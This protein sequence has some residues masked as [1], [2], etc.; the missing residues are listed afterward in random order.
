MMCR[1]KQNDTCHKNKEQQS[2]A[3]SDIS[4]KRRFLILIEFQ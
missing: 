2:Y 4:N 1:T 3:T